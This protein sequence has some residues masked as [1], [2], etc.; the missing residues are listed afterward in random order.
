MVG[1]RAHDEHVQEDT[2]HK[3]QQ[4]ADHCENVGF[5]VDVGLHLALKEAQHLDGGDFL[6]ALGDID[7]HQVVQY[8]K[9]QHAG[10]Q[11]DHVHDIVDARDGVVQT[12]AHAAHLREARYP[13]HLPASPDFCARLLLR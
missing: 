11:D 9:S 6:C 12:R 1:D 4:H 7:V 5:A 8:H 10:T 2:A 13:V 3:A